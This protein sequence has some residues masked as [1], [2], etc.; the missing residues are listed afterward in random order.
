MKWLNSLWCKAFHVGT[1]EEWDYDSKPSG[2]RVCTRVVHKCA[3]C[4]RDK[5][6]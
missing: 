6:P 3:E 4:G 2:L 5:R 1:Y